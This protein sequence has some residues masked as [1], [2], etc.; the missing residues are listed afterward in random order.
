MLATIYLTISALLFS[1]SV[2]KRWFVLS[3]LSYLFFLVVFCALMPLPGKDEKVA[4]SPTQVVFRFDEFRYLQ[5]TG[6][7]C[8]G[9]L[10]YID[11][12]KQVY[13]QLA[14]H[15]AEVLTE[16]FAHTVGDYIF[17]PFEDYSGSLYSQDGGRTFKIID[18]NNHTIRPSQANV[19][20]SV[21]VNNE[22]FIDS[23]KGLFRTPLAFGTDI[24]VEILSL[25]DQKKM[26]GYMRYMGQRWQDAPKTFPSLPSNYH[27]WHN[28]RCDID[29]EQYEIIYDRYEPLHQLQLRLRQM[30]GL[31]NKEKHNETT[32]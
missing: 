4:I 3:G 15:S 12:Q 8:R 11:E 17:V 2:L 23:T 10:Y 14:V 20:R 29:L 16:P 22:L 32:N 25:T 18:V 21:V 13:N 26:D 9:K 6:S 30:I 19:M 31:A 5:L 27:G 1:V 7:G 24:G 28:W